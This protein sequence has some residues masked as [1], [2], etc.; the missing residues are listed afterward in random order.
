MAIDTIKL[1]YPADDVLIHKYRQYSDRF[2]KISPDGEVIWEKTSCTKSLPS[3]FGSLR[4]TYTNAAD[5]LSMGFKNFTR[6][7]I[8]FEFSL[9]KWHSETG[10]NNR[11]TELTW[12]L[13]KLNE[14]IN[15]LSEVFEYSF[16]EDIFEVMR[17]DIAENYILK[18]GSVDDYLRAL[19]L[20]FS[21]HQNGEKK[22]M[23]FDGAIQY[24]SSWIGKK[25]Y[26]KFKEFVQVEKKKHTSRYKEG[27]HDMKTIEGVKRCLNESEIEEL[28]RMLRFEVEF[29][30]KFLKKSGLT[31]I[32]SIPDLLGRFE[33]EKQ[34]YMTVKNLRTGAVA[35]SG[36]EYMIVDLCKRYG[37]IGAKDEFLKDHSKASWYQH[38]KNLKMKGVY[39]EC[40][41]NEEWRGDIAHAD[42]GE[43][44][45]LVKAA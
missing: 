13:I 32:A 45:E 11:N 37:Q 33:Q 35:L 5:Q 38:K 17:V 25:I 36:T 20:K 28:V 31:K 9:Q 26:S 21:P 1:S 22:L 30:R 39:L 44:F 2:Q 6:S 27:G 14:W 8:D 41:L 10:Y 3:H 7:T 15:T 19:E 18:K 12:D 4:I 24:G 34:K 42:F 29:R 43:Q 23:R 40:V 16:T